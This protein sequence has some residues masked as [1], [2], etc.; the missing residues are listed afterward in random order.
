MDT[1]ALIGQQVLCQHP[2][3]SLAAGWHKPVKEH[4]LQFEDTG[5]AGSSGGFLGSKT[6]T[7]TAKTPSTELLCAGVFWL[8]LI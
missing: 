2:L 1:L 8:T 6:E 3:A 5:T 4:S 7:G